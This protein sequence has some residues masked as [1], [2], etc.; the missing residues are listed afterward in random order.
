MESETMLICLVP[1]LS[2]LLKAI[3]AVLGT[4]ST[5]DVAEHNA[6]V[7][8]LSYG[9][10][11]AHMLMLPRSSSSWPPAG[12]YTF[13]YRTDVLAPENAKLVTSLKCLGRGGD[14]QRLPAPDQSEHAVSLTFS[15]E[16]RRCTSGDQRVCSRF[17]F[18][19]S[20]SC[21]QAGVVH[22]V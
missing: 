5:L 11:V 18:S 14:F 21:A 9:L 3:A 17:R 20:A 8:N 16:T 7:V 12:T 13:M 1:H 19:T 22:L 2:A 6:C 10:H 15:H 4:S